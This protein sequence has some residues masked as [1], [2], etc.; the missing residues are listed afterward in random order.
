MKCNPC[1]NGL[2]VLVLAALAGCAVSGPEPPPTYP[3]SG[4][5]YWKKGEPVRGGTI[6]FKM[7]PPSAIYTTNTEIRQD[8]TFTLRTLAGN[9][10]IDGAPEGKYQVTVIP[11]S[12]DQT[13]IRQFELPDTYTVKADGENKFVISL[14]KVP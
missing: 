9:K 12:D 2:P 4:T 6:E 13:K 5:V 11:A 10:K 1:R 8:G 14:D 3:V 7:I